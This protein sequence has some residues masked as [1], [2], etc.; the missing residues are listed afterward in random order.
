MKKFLQSILP[1]ILIIAVFTNS[2]SQTNQEDFIEKVANYKV[3][4]KELAYLQLNKSHFLKGEQLGFAAYVLNESTHHPDISDFNLYVTIKN[5]KD[6][7]IKKEMYL[8]TDGTTAGTVN[9][10]ST[11]TKGNY[12]ITAFTSYMQNFDEPYHFSESFKVLSSSSNEKLPREF[13]GK[14]DIQFLP[15]SGHFLNDVINNVGVITTDS[16]GKSLGNGKIIIKDENEELISII[17]L[18]KFGIGRFSFIPDN[19][20]SY[21]AVFAY[22]DK[23]IPVEFS[24]E[25]H[26]EGLILSVSEKKSKVEVLI[27]TNTY[28]L[29]LYKSKKFFLVAQDNENFYSF[30]ITFEDFTT[31]SVVFNLNEMDAG[32]NIFTLFNDKMEPIAERLYF[33]HENF[34]VETSENINISSKKDS[35]KINIPFKPEKE[36]KVSISVL[37]QN[38]ISYVRNHNILS[39]N[40]L[41]PYIKGNIENAA[42][43]FTN[44]NPEKKVALDNLLLTRGWSSYNWSKIINETTAPV[45]IEDRFSFRAEITSNDLNRKKLRYMV[46]GIGANPPK[47]IEIQEGITTFFVDEYIPYEGEKLKISRIKSNDNLVPANLKIQFSPNYFPEFN[48]ADKPH[49]LKAEKLENKQSER[50]YRYEGLNAEAELLDE[51]IL[52][53]KA[54]RPMDRARELGKNVFT[55]ILVVSKKNKFRYLSDL[56]KA[57]NLIVNDDPKSFWVA[58]TRMQ[59]TPSNQIKTMQFYL[60]DFP[61]PNY[62]FYMYPLVDVDYI[63]INKTGMGGGLKVANG[64]IKVYTKRDAHNSSK[65]RNRI[66]IYDIPLAYAKEKKYYVP[67]YENTSDEFFQNYGVIDWK[68]EVRFEEG[69]AAVITIKK[70]EVDFQLIIEGVTIDGDLIHSIQQV[71][72]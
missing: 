49:L 69:K 71:Q 6:S 9:I 18:N 22:M 36:G 4:N 38:T 29:P 56:L 7:I 10:D 23:E 33:N 58:T 39:Y 26:D 44:I 45:K 50:F 16:L 27:K 51:V 59:V 25:I 31:A 62:M 47:F 19:N 28:S 5:A 70:P 48:M 57:E 30:D 24:P 2:N 67:K 55:N 20:K 1:F 11:F 68:P 60:N 42:W 63:E 8:I 61:M 15:E 32:M 46:H 72:K 40:Y 66:K 53:A 12:T 37:P 13:P 64:T 65:S 52:S 35:L 3:L 41:K 43:Y 34:A 21:N 14:F 54:E 17:D